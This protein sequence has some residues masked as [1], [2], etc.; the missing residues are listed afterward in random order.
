MAQIHQEV[1]R[2]SLRDHIAQDV[3][4]KTQFWLHA[5]SVSLTLTFAFCCFY[6]YKRTK[7][8]ASENPAPLCLN[9]KPKCLCSGL[10]P[11][12]DG[13]RKEKINISSCGGWPF[14]K[15]FVRLTASL[16]LIP[17]LSPSFFCKRN[18]HPDSNKMVILRHYSVIFSVCQLPE[19]S[20][21]PCLNTS[22]L[23]F[24]GLLCGKQRE[25]GLSNKDD[26][27]AFK[28]TWHPWTKQDTIASSTT[29]HEP[30]ASVLSSKALDH[31]VALV[32]QKPHV[33]ATAIT[34]AQSLSLQV[35]GTQILSSLLN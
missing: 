29:R 22:S 11:P 7:W 10:C 30:A 25:V 28:I 17:H 13:Y 8:P 2:I 14:Q 19:Q 4:G 1:W 16:T 18:W 26:T 5:G 32:F 23:E 33:A 9:V 27:K 12:V 24:I 20:S 31:P 3:I 34:T 6:H 21:V 35:W 15:T